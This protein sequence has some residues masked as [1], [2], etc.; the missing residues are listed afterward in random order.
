MQTFFS[1]FFSGNS[2]VS[3]WNR[4]HDIVFIQVFFQGFLK[5][6]IKLLKAARRAAK[7]S[8][9]FGDF[10]DSGFFRGL[11]RGAENK[12]RSAAN[13]MRVRRVRRL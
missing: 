4:I 1:V 6:Y 3:V 8:G 10:L 11:F 7:K 9:V 13:Q 5:S 12:K 2:G